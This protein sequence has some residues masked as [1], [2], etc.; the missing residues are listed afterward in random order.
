MCIIGTCLI[1]YSTHL[2]QVS[3]L[4]HQVA[5]HP[6]PALGLTP[7]ARLIGVQFLLVHVLLNDYVLRK[8]ACRQRMSVEFNHVATM[9]S[10]TDSMQLAT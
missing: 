4:L 7:L 10:C 6:A 3:H 2:K 5:V 8:W 9:M 1:N